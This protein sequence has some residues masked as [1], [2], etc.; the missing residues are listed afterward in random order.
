MIKIMNELPGNVLGV[1][2]EGHITGMDYENVLIPAV[3]DKLK[4]Y[5]KISMIYHLGSTFTGFDPEAMFDDAKIG[6]K[7]LSRWDKIAL[8][9]DHE[10]INSFA[11]FFGHLIS[12]ELRVFKNAELDDAKKWIII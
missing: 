2:A 12:C 11:K 8:V 9:S 5:K 10:I 3:D 7:N 6:M 1:T 4:I